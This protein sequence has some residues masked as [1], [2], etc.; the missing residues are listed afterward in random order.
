MPLVHLERL[1]LFG[2]PVRVIRDQGG[3]FSN[4]EFGD[5]CASRNRNSHLIATGSYRASG[6][7]ERMMSLLKNVLTVVD[8]GLNRSLQDAIDDIQLFIKST[9]YG[10]VKASPLELSISC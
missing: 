10:L 7:V 8:V 3:C 6:Q 9:I 4:R 5:Y 1:S 2:A